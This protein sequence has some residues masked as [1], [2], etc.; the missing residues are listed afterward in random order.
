MDPIST[1]PAYLRAASADVINSLLTPDPDALWLMQGWVFVWPAGFWTLD[2]VRAYLSGVPND[3]MI[4]LDLFAERSPV[5]TREDRDFGGKKWIWNQLLNF[6]STSGLKGELDVVRHEPLEALAADSNVTGVGLTMEGIDN[7]VIMYDA[8]LQLVWTEPTNNKNNEKNDLENFVLEWTRERYGQA[9][10]QATHAWQTLA[11]SVY[12]AP[13]LPKETMDYWGVIES[14]ITRAP[15]INLKPSRGFKP[16]LPFYSTTAVASAWVSLWRAR[17]EL[18]EKE[19]WRYDLVD[20]TRQVLSDLFI[21]LV[22]EM[23]RVWRKKDLEGLKRVREE[24]LGMILDVDR[25]LGTDRHTMLG[26]WI[27]WARAWGGE[28]GGEGLVGMER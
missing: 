27:G 25:L 5:W 23:N 12:S 26:R 18:R 19:T 11:K 1:D 7:N 14:L 15:D 21:E 3:R 13:P 2:R 4:I 10:P 20:V 16:T 28:G 17:G 9:H 6:G 22:A 8:L 24:I